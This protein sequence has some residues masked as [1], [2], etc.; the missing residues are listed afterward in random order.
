MMDSLLNLKIEKF[1]CFKMITQE[2]GHC[3]LFLGIAAV[4]EAADGDDESAV[5]NNFLQMDDGSQNVV[6]LLSRMQRER[7][8]C[9]YQQQWMRVMTMTTR[10]RL[11]PATISC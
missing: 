7:V 5:C 3:C 4:G 8:T 9:V 11:Q 10:W 2:D 1:K 6:K